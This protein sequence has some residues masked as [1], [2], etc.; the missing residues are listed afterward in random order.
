MGRGRAV[1]SKNGPMPPR[2]SVLLPDGTI[3]AGAQPRPAGA[4]PRMDEELL[5]EALRWMMKSRFYDQRVIA[6]QRQGQFGVFSPGM[7]QEASI[8]GSAMAVDPARDW[9]VPQ[10]RELMATVH[11]G[12]PLEVITAQYLGKIAPARI[13]D[14]VRV[15]PTQVSIAAQLPQA[16]GLAWGLR[17]RGQDSVVIAYIGDGGS[18]EGDFHEALNLAGVVKAP[19]VFFLQ[20]NQWAISTSRR[21]Q[22][23][24][25]S[26]ALRAA[27]Y[28]FEGFEVDGNDVMAVYE[29]AC[30]AVDRARSGGGPSLIE[31]VTYRMSFHNT[32][33][34]PSRYQDPKEFEEARTRDPIERVQRYLA[35]LGLWDPQREAAWTEEIREENEQALKHA[36]GAAAPRPED[37]FANVYQ[38]PPRRVLRQRA[39]LV[40]GGGG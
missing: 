40:D 1:L 8:V 39:E 34:N 11:H 19:I 3:A 25:K 38:D 17:L 15:L 16:T 7:G 18:S 9:M 12:L 27:G 10:Y 30:E 37:V 23:A 21:V 24:T 14:G 32:T 13:P 6:L 36:M 31:A 4:Q 20:N 22:S 35:T 29:V 33:D 5:L 26:F 2:R 28:G